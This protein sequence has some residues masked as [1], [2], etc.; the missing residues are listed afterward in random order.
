MEVF[1]KPVTKKA[2]IGLDFAKKLLVWNQLENCRQMPWKGEKDPYRIW[3]SEVILQQTRVEQ[4]LKYYENFIKTFPTVEALANAPEEKV[5]KLWEGLGYYSRCRNLIHTARY[6]S[7]E[8]NG[9]FPSHYESILKLKGVGHYT[10]AAIASFAYNLHYAVL[11]G[12]VFRVLSRIYAIDTAIDSVEGKKLFTQLSQ[13][14]LPKGCPGEYNQA[15]MDFGAT[16]CKPQPD[17][18]SCFFNNRCQAYNQGITDVLPVKEKVVAVSKRFL[19]FLFLRC[20]DEIAIQERTGKDIWQHLYQPLLI[21][22][23][24]K[25]TKSKLLEALT[26]KISLP[27]Y[28]IT[29]ATSVTQKLTHQLIQ[30]NIILLDLSL[31]IELEDH[32]WIN[33]SDLK[34]YPFP[35]TLKQFTEQID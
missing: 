13:Q 24:N 28:T 26:E 21:E 5:F 27:A 6:I 23:K 34:K 7:T 17:C 9:Q 4:G 33:T 14:I 20:N 31:K 30:F 12:N 18:E 1:D 2:K 11:D 22:T 35:K 8:L 3:L 15:I 19:N 16:I 10:A 29:K 25:V 32:Q